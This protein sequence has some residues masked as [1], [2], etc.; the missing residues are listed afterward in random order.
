MSAV[1]FRAWAD[2]EHP[3]HDGTPVTNLTTA[4]PARIAAAPAP[5]E[6]AVRSE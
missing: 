4:V 2:P 3:A 1:W 5:A 6:V